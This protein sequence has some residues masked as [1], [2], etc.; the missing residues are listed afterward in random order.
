MA[1]TFNGRC[2]HGCPKPATRQVDDG[3]YGFVHYRCED[4]AEKEGKHGWTV[5]PPTEET[6]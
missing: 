3:N 6:T 4:C 5:R 1:D 2:A